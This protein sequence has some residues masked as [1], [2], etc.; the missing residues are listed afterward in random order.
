MVVAFAVLGLGGV[1]FDHFFGGPVSTTA[2]TAGTDPPA[3]STTLAPVSKTTGPGGTGSSQL[4][5]SI[6]ALLSLTKLTPAPA[7]SFTLT[8]KTGR[9]ISLESLRGKIVLLTFF[10]STLQRHLPRHGDRAATRHRR[11][12]K[13]CVT[14]GGA[15]REHR[16]GGD[17]ASF[18]DSADAAV[19]PGTGGWHFLTGSIDQLD[20]VWKAYGVKIEVQNSTGIV[21]H[22]NLLY[23]IDAKG[24]LRLRAT[25]FANESTNG[26]FSLA[27]S[28]ETRFAS[29]IASSVRSLI[30][31]DGSP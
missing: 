31:P 6:P 10:D 27:S 30:Q 16:P 29:G 3:L 8:S 19:G 25:P 12:A 14:S 2:V 1:V 11:S 20:A 4:P 5:A 22:N 24:R 18:V 17:I 7:P 15:R 26:T 21:S 9:S 23:F 28:T 13:R